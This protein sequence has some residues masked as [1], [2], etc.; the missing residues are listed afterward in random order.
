MF[1]KLELAY[2]KNQE[3]ELKSLQ[4][5]LNYLD[6]SNKHLQLI[7]FKEARIKYAHSNKIK[8]LEVLCK[9]I[10]GKQPI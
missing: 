1:L 3:I 8:D 7:P 5:E 4:I 9:Q 10:L 6:Y 2:N